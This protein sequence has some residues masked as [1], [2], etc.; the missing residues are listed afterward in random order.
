MTPSSHSQRHRHLTGYTLPLTFCP[1]RHRRLSQVYTP[2]TEV[3]G[4]RLVRNC[5]AALLNVGFVLPDA[6]EKYAVVTVIV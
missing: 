1:H 2:E 6:S 3:E 5:L 4:T